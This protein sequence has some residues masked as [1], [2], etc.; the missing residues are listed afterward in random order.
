MTI[1]KVGHSVCVSTF[2]F[3][4]H[5]PATLVL[6]YSRVT[7]L[8][9]AF[10]FQYLR[11]SP[12]LAPSAS[13]PYLLLLPDDGP[14]G[15]ASRADLCYSHSSPRISAITLRAIKYESPKGSVRS[16]LGQV[17]SEN[18]V[19]FYQLSVLTND[20]ALSECLYAEVRNE[21]KAELCPPNTISRLGIAKSPAK[22]SSDFIVPNGYV[23]Q[24]FDDSHHTPTSEEDSNAESGPNLAT[25]EE[26]KCTLS[27]E[28]LEI[29]IHGISTD[30]SRTTAFHQSLNFLQIE[31]EGK[32]ASGVP[33]METLCVTYLI[34][35][36]LPVLIV[37][38]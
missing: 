6:L 8:T 1:V 34:Q 14:V 25:L 38:S 27:F 24:D 33:T 36:R 32:V 15:L 30:T 18:N 26:D 7:G 3:A 23:D 35:R 31:I 12:K 21:F 9:N 22:V 37:S 4:Q 29:E 5:A 2:A 13:D 16:G 19:A 10:T 11:P 28:W 17:Y 20:L